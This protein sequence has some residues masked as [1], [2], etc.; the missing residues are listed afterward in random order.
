LDLIAVEKG[1]ERVC[2][3]SNSGHKLWDFSAG[4]FLKIFRVNNKIYLLFWDKNSHREKF[5]LLDDK[6]NVVNTFILN[7]TDF[8]KKNDK[9]QVYLA[10]IDFDSL[11]ELIFTSPY[12][13]KI[14][15][16]NLK[17]Q[18]I[19]IKKSLVYLP[20]LFSSPEEYERK[21]QVSPCYR[22]DGRS[23]LFPILKDK[24]APYR[25]VL[26]Y[27][28]KKQWLELYKEGKKLSR[29]YFSKLDFPYIKMNPFFTTFTVGNL[30]KSEKGCELILGARNRIYVFNLHLE[31]VKVYTNVFY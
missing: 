29:F 21:F 20:E 22:K 18:V 26:E 14:K 3:L 4:I 19:P 1:K 17:N 23:Y 7:K 28:A 13:G 16:Y 9:Y 2:A 31:F 10:D 8:F 6:S 24:L 15:I 12:G 5:I 30:F 25:V 11:P 27:G